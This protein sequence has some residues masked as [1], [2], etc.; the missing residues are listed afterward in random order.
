MFLFQ[1]HSRRAHP[2]LLAA[3]GSDSG[4]GREGGW[5]HAGGSGPA[6]Q[7]RRRGSEPLRLTTSYRVCE[8]KRKTSFLH[9]RVSSELSVL[10]MAGGMQRKLS[11][12]MAFVGGSK[13]VIL[14]EPTSGVDPYSRRSIWDLLLKY[15]TGK[16]VPLA[17]SS[18]H[19]VDYKYKSQPPMY[20]FS[21]YTKN[22]TNLCSSPEALELSSELI[23]RKNS[24]TTKAKISIIKSIHFSICW[25]RLLKAVVNYVSDN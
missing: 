24:A 10:H 5:G 20:I 9:E 14:D 25:Q 3:E 15:R 22:E 7:E 23:K 12:A 1:S 21:C 2:V 6:A 13:V 17:P 8:R 4:G 11:V 18:I 16:N 19:V